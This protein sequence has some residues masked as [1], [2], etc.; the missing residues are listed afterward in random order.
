MKDW[1][2]D[3]IYDPIATIDEHGHPPND[4]HSLITGPKKAPVV[5]AIREASRILPSLLL[6]SI[7]FLV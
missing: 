6:F 2:Q 5:E 3:I 7:Y 1:H 4:A